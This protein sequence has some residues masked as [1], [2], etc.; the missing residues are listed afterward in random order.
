MVVILGVADVILMVYESS[1]RGVSCKRYLTAK[2]EPGVGVVA[3]HHYDCVR[4]LRL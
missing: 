4:G 3:P 1:F 2:A